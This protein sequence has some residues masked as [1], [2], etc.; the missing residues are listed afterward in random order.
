MKH[1][2]N[3]DMYRYNSMRLHCIVKEVFVPENEEELKDLITNLK[4]EQKP[5]HLLGACSNVILPPRL[6]STLVM[7]TSFNKNIIFHENVLECGASVRIQHL[8]R[9]GQK[10]GL[11]GMEFLFSVPCSVGGAIIMNAGRGNV[12]FSIGKYV[13]HVR[14]LNL[15]TN[16]IE[17]LT[18]AQCDYKYRHS[19][20]QHSNKIVLSTLLSLE[21]LGI[22]VIENNIVE[23]KKYA[24]HRLD[25]RRPSCGSIFNKCNSRIMR[26]LKGVRIG[27]AEWSPKTVNWISN[28][29][30]AKYWQVRWLIVLACA[31]HILF[32][33]EYHLEVEIWKK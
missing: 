22:S 5:F 27:G 31:L 12:N 14:C 2:N 7:L 16:E 30:N 25:D 17:I 29:R 18:K 8:I 21:P 26:L 4:S 6:N 33:K 11:G 9:E 19:A 3:F 28:A 15:D 13:E 24:E 32:F 20:L 23:R 1:Y 10:R